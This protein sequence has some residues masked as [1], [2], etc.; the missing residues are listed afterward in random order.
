ME[1]M[2]KKHNS[3]SFQKIEGVNIVKSWKT[4]KKWPKIAENGLK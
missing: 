1:I 3:G 4:R 2:S